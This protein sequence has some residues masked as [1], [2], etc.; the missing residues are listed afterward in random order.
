MS[1]VLDAAATNAAIAGADPFPPAGFPASQWG[2]N[3]A[4]FVASPLEV[5]Y[6]W[7]YDDGPGSPNIDCSTAN[8]A[9]CFGHRLNILLPLPCTSCV[10][11]ASWVSRDDDRG[12]A[13]EL[14]VETSGS[15]AVDFTW[16]EEEPYLSTGGA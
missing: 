2:G 16:A 10:A 13:T 9:G 8:P 12:N 7:M 14:I 5:L 11:G 1:S 6:Y 3:M 15:S 4:Q